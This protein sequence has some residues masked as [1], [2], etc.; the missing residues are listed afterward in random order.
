[1]PTSVNFMFGYNLS[2]RILDEHE[3]KL[4]CRG[5]KFCIEQK[6]TRTLDLKTDIEH[7]SLFP[8]RLLY[9]SAEEGGLLMKCLDATGD[10]VSE[11][12]YIYLLGIV[13]NETDIL[14]IDQES[15]FIKIQ[16]N[17]TTTPYLND[18]SDYDC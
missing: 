2:N 13:S 18:L 9:G 1:M 17:G 6:V 10:S 11:L 4:L 3:L 7:A 15:N 8:K 12:D 14:P 5:W 16:W